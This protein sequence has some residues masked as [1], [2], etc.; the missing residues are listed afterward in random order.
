MPAPAPAPPAVTSEE[1]E[2]G[3]VH[4]F[5]GDSNQKMGE[6]LQLINEPAIFFLDGH[7]NNGEP[8]WGALETIKNHSIKEH[9][10]I[11]DD[12]SN[13]FGDGSIVKEKLFS[14]RM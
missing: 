5:L 12:V 6:M 8:L 1:I 4:L 2:E 7:F 3:K 10:I 13:Y 9:T 14:L 11:V